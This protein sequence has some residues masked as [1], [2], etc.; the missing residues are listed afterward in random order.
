MVGHLAAIG[1]PQRPVAAEQ[2]AH[3]SVGGVRFI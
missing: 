1:P 3:L 2:H